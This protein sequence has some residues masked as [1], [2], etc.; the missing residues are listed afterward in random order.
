MDDASQF[1]G[2]QRRNF[3]WIYVLDEDLRLIATPAISDDTLPENAPSLVRDAATR[4]A[5]QSWHHELLMSVGPALF[6]R[7]FPMHGPDGSCIVVYLEPF[8]ERV[9]R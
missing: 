1:L 7:V 5:H 8:R 2:V 4:W 3:G 6:A 9:T